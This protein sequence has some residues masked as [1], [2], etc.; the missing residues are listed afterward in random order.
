MEEDKENFEVRLS[1]IEEELN[2]LRVKNVSVTTDEE[3]EEIRKKYN[4]LLEEKANINKTLKVYEEGTIES[5]LEEIDRKIKFEEIKAKKYEEI[6]EENLKYANE[7]QY[8]QEAIKEDEEKLAG[9]KT[10]IEEA[11][12]YHANNG[13]VDF[14]DVFDRFVKSKENP[15]YDEEPVKVVGSRAWQWV[16]EHK[17]Q[18]LIALGLTAIAVSVVVLATQ[19]LPALVAANN[20]A[21]TAGLLSQMATN[22]SLWQAASIGEQAALHGANIALANQ[23]TAVSGMANSFNAASG[24]WT[25]GGQTLAAAANTAAVAATKAAGTAAVLQ[26]LGITTGLGGVG[27]VGAGLLRNPSKE[28]KTI[29]GAIKNLKAKCEL[30]E[31]VEFQS[32]A[33]QIDSKITNSN[34][35]SAIERKILLKKFASVLR[36]RSKYNSQQQKNSELEEQQQVENNFYAL[37]EARKNTVLELAAGELVDNPEEVKDIDVEIF[38]NGNIYEIDENGNIILPNEE[39]A[40]SM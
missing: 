26:G 24:A 17:K 13:N 40:K 36:K 27:L 3:L 37:E 12:N 6:K 33:E 25:I 28:Y 10:K 18:I 16:K 1:E 30:I 20:A 2:S 32:I 22:G 8:D 38:E 9:L 21:Q 15:I 29:S 19:V 5:K 31:E 39:K 23:V 14:V 7:S 4:D 35:L 11:D 34:E